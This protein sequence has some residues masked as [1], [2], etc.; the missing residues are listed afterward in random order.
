MICSCFARLCAKSMKTQ[1]LQKNKSYIK[2]S[3]SIERPTISQGTRRHTFR[4]ASSRPAR[5]SWPEPDLWPEGVSLAC[6]GSNF[7]RLVFGCIDSYD[8][9]QRLIFQ[10]FSRSTRFAFLC[11]APNSNLQS[12]APLI[13]AIFWKKIHDFFIILLNFHSNP[14]FSPRFS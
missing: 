9:D 4:T 8:S 7:E 14:S 11:T 3:R 12:F 10:H 6:F 5:P 1:I 13:F 2:P